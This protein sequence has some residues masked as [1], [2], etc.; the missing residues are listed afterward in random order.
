MTAHIVAQGC[1]WCESCLHD[2]WGDCTDEQ[3]VQLGDMVVAEFHRLV[4]G[5]TWTPYTS[6]VIA[7]IV[8]DLPNNLTDYLE[9]ANHTIF[10]EMVDGKITLGFDHLSNHHQG[11]M[12]LDI[13]LFV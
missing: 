9:E 2:G 8:T 5:S 6:E 13:P 10:E 7:E 12:R 11:G 4:P 3:A 1:E